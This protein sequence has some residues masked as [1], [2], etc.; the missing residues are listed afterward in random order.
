MN[1]SEFDPEYKKL[2]D[3]FSLLSQPSRL[4]ILQLI[5]R[6]EMCV[7]HLKA[8]LGLRQAYISQQLMG[9]RQAGYLTTRRQGRSI[10][11]SLVDPRLLELIEVAAGILGCSLLLPP[12][13]DVAGCPVL[14]IPATP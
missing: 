7:C 8:T 9:L 1:V 11:Y 13:E 6:N 4:Q 10:Y 14:P 2:A 3:L 5:G 12:A